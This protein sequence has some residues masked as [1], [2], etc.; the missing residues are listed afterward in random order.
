MN[1][2]C[3]CGCIAEDDRTWK[4]FVGCSCTI[5]FAERFGRLLKAGSSESEPMSAIEVR[6]EQLR[7]KREI[8]EKTRRPT[9]SSGTIR[10]CENPVTRPGIEPGSPWW[11]ASGLTARPLRPR[12]VTNKNILDNVPFYNELSECQCGGKRYPRENPP[13]RGTTPTCENPEV[14]QPGIEP[15]PPW[16]GGEFRLGSQD[17]A[18]KSR[19]NLFTSLNSEIELSVQGQ[20]ARERLRATITRTPSTSSLLGARRWSPTCRNGVLQSASGY[21]LAS[22]QSNQQVNLSPQAVANQAHGLFPERRTANRRLGRPRHFFPVHL[23]TLWPRLVS[24]TRYCPWDDLTNQTRPT[25]S[26]SNDGRTGN[27]TQVLL[28]TSPVSYH[29]ATSLGEY[30]HRRAHLDCW[31]TFVLSRWSAGGCPVG[32]YLYP[33]SFSPAGWRSPPQ[34]QSPCYWGG[35]VTTHQ[36]LAFTS[37]H[38]GV[39]S[40]ARLLLPAPRGH[41]T[42]QDSEEQL[43]LHANFNVNADTLISRDRGKL[44][45]KHEHTGV[46]FTIGS[47]FIRH[48][49]DDSEPIADLQKTSSESHTVRYGVT[50]ATL[51]DCNQWTND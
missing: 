40:Y 14:V 3:I 49:L 27:R 43:W 8:P 32:A 17:P 16:E 50:H 15:D 9:A 11:E 20:E 2:T 5:R 34:Q 19:P 44:D 41:R 36:Y 48:A 47:Q 4:Q 13:T 12:N 37:I 10:T 45:V 21:L 1:A 18:V 51:W 6:M 29:C 22:R 38:H 39:Y 25:E 23:S 30:G 35:G 42:S 33:T 24:P 28:N 26:R 7:G 46:D 31:T